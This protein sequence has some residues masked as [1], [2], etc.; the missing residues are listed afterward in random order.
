MA[1][2]LRNL[3]RSHSLEETEDDRKL[4][5]LGLLAQLPLPPL[6]LHHLQNLSQKKW[7][8]HLWGGLC[9]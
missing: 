3:S 5:P 1:Q 9:G 4:G 7:A 2:R 6:P 8:A